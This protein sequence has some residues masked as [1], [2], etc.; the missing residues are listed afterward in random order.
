MTVTRSRSVKAGSMAPKHG[1]CVVPGWWYDSAKTRRSF[2]LGHK[3]KMQAAVEL[4][5]LAQVTILPSI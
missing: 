2:S 5:A 1:R 4:R 3:I